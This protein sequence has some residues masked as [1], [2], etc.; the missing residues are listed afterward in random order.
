VDDTP[1]QLVKPQTFMNRSEAAIR[2]VLADAAL[3]PR[4][5]LLVLVDEAALPL[6]R[7]RLRAR[8]SHGG[9]RGLESVEEAVGSREYARLRIGVGPQPPTQPM[10]DYVLE[11]FTTGELAVLRDLLPLLC[12][13]VTCWVTDGVEVAMN[14]YNR[15]PPPAPD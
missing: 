5:D 7:Y 12:E 6:G 1:V 3:D 4:H 8:G 2:H 10:E 14:R 9:H 15:R 13:A 11:E